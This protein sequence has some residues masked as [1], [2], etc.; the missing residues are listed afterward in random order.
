MGPTA[1]DRKVAFHLAKGEMSVMEHACREGGVGHA[2]RDAAQKWIDSVLSARG[3][4]RGV[5]GLAVVR[6]DVVDPSF[7]TKR[8]SPLSTSHHPTFGRPRFEAQTVRPESSIAQVTQASSIG[9]VAAP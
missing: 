7:R 8:G 5:G 1:A 2:A 4:E 3:D 6:V 9:R